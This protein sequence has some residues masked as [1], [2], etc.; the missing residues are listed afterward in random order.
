MRTPAPATAAAAYEPMFL[1]A[2]PVKVGPAVELEP[3]GAMGDVG[4]IGEPVAAGP[5]T[6]P[7]EPMVPVAK[8]VDAGDDPE[9]LITVVLLHEHSVS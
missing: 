5:V 8:P 2:A 4:T 6:A 3:V 1:D 7:V 9:E